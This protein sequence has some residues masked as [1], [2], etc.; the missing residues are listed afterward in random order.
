M[1]NVADSSD[2]FDLKNFKGEIHDKLMDSFSI[3]SRNVRFKSL[4]SIGRCFE[5]GSILKGTNRKRYCSDKCKNKLRRRYDWKIIR[6]KIKKR[7]ND[8]CQLCNQVIN[9]YKDSSSR[10]HSVVLDYHVDHIIEIAKATTNREQA[11]LFFDLNNLQLV[12][13]PCHKE[14][15]VKFLKRRNKLPSQDLRKFF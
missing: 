4:I 2:I 7:D 6:R 5:C 14:K 3:S 13:V 12:C 1:N 15:T 9:S 10:W 8:Q 11:E